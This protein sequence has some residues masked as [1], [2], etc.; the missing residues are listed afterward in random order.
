MAY[1]IETASMQK[2]EE[3][4]MEVTE[5]RMLRWMF[6]VTRED[7]IRN[8]FMRRSTKVVEISKENSARE[9]EVVRTPAEKG[10]R[11]CWK[12]YSGDESSGKKEEGK[13]KKEM[14]RLCK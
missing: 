8:E 4:K 7:R 1:G 12:I 6:E 2:T 3:K 5:M 11:T 10:R 13:A 14:A 9:T